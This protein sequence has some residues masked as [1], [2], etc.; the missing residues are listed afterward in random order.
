MNRLPEA[1]IHH[2]ESNLFNF[3]QLDHL[4]HGNCASTS[5]NVIVHL[6]GTG[7][8]MMQQGGNTNVLTSSSNQPSASRKRQRS[9][10]RNPATPKCNFCPKKFANQNL[11]GVCTQLSIFKASF[12]WTLM[13]KTV[14]LIEHMRVVPVERDLRP[15]AVF[16]NTSVCTWVLKI[17]P[18]S[19]LTV[20][21][22]STRN[23]ISINTKGRNHS[24]HL[25]SILF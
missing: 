9:S 2:L 12:S 17:G 22:G 16:S 23:H 15:K 21:K 4:M 3:R 10:G 19:A 1:E 14:L 24:N 18:I 5:S 13:L 20:Q 8:S 11:V 25:S 7:E 6:N